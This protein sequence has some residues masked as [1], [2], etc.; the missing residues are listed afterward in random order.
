MLVRDRVL[1]TLIQMGLLEIRHR[2]G[3]EYNI[4][5]SFAQVRSGKSILNDWQLNEEKNPSAAVCQ[6]TLKAYQSSRQGT[7]VPYVPYYF[8]DLSCLPGQL[9]SLSSTYWVR[10]GSLVLCADHRPRFSRNWNSTTSKK[11]HFQWFQN[12]LSHNTFPS[13][14]SSACVT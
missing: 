10:H 8:H 4:S 12:L 6:L 9:L 2:L 11:N 14:L 5:N 1:L 3:R 7:N 13:T